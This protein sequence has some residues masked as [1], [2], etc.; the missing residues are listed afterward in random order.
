MGGEGLS[1]RSCSVDATTVRRAEM[2][3]QLRILQQARDAA[4]GT[5]DSSAR[6]DAGEAWR[7]RAGGTTVGVTLGV[8][9]GKQVGAPGDSILGAAKRC[10]C[11]FR[12]RT[13]RDDAGDGRGG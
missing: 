10:P 2:R 5:D 7:W 11:P 6:N 3:E 12:S 13:D 4:D 8:L 9:A 1:V